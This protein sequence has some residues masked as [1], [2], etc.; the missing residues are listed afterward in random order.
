MLWETAT[1]RRRRK[2]D[3]RGAPEI[4]GGFSA[5][6]RHLWTATNNELWCWDLSSGRRMRSLVGHRGDVKAVAPFPNALRV[7][8]AG[9]DGA[10]VVWRA[11][12]PQQGPRPPADVRLEALWAALAAED[13]ES[14]YD[15]M[16][17][18]AAVP[19]HAASY[20]R[21]RFQRPPAADESR[22]RTLLAQLD[23]D[24]FTTRER[25]AKDL[26]KFGESAEP[27]LRAQLA[28]TKSPEVA[29]RLEVLLQSVT[30]SIGDADSLRALRSLEV[31]E[32][33][34][35]PAARAALEEL[36]S[37]VCGAKLKARA[38]K[39]LRRMQQLSPP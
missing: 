32:R 22:I 29:Q 34:A 10:A 26:A 19:E 31:L 15:A 13:A 38:E 35:T 3:C 1:W 5:D 20:L 28:A 27:Q 36:A 39:S 2:L 18:M 37:G 16:W 21:N 30:Q 6:G 11:A 14:A 17:A 23:D 12:M 33:I 4:L 25:A 9:D 7:A 8:S 24:H